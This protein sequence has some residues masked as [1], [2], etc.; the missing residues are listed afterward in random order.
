MCTVKM[1]PMVQMIKSKSPNPKIS[2]G[3][4]E[5]KISACM[6]AP[7]DRPNKMVIMFIR[8]FWAVSDNR[9]TTPHSRMKLPNMNI[10]IKGATAGMSSTIKKVAISGN[11]S[12]SLCETGRSWRILIL[13]CSGLVSQ[14]IRGGCMSGT[15]AM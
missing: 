4:Q 3:F 13:R 14:R 6:V 9:L 7:T 1:P 8:E 5:R 10:P 11:I 12:F 15:M 2:N